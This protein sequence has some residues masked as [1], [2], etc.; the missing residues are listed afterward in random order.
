MKFLIDIQLPSALAEFLRSRGLEAKHVI[1]LGLDSASDEA[2]WSFA[3]T[4]KLI[5]VSK[6]EDFFHLCKMKP[7]TV[8]LVW[9]RI[10]NCRSR[11]L[12]SAFEKLLDTIL[13]GLKANEDVIE[14]R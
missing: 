6:D 12:I 13:A 10:G 5:I 1:E 7:Q 9:V 2:I 14:I 11:H 8:Q 3:K 4:E